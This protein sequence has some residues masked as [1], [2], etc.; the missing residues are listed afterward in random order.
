MSNFPS[1]GR[2]TRKNKVVEAGSKTLVGIA[3]H[4]RSIDSAPKGYSVQRPAAVANGFLLFFFGMSAILLSS[5]L[6]IK[7]YVLP[8]M[9][10]DLIFFNAGP[11]FAVLPV[12]LFFLSYFLT[13]ALFAHAKVSMK[14]W[15]AISFCGKSILLWMII[16]GIVFLIWAEQRIIVPIFVQQLIAGIGA[17][18][19]FPHTIMANAHLP[20]QSNSP[21]TKR[22]PVMGYLLLGTAF[23]F[24]FVIALWLAWKLDETIV[25][26]RAIALLGGLGPGVFLVQQAFA[27]FMATI[28]YSM[29]VRSGR[30]EFAP[31]IAILVPAHNEAHGIADCIAS[32]D[33]AAETYDGHVKL[34]IVDNCSRDDTANV[35]KSALTQASHI[36][37]EVFYCGTPGKAVALNYGLDHISE[38]F[39]VRIDA[40]TAIGDD[41]LHIA[42]NHF[43][44]PN[45]GAV[46]GLPLPAERTGVLNRIRLIEILLR[47]GFY[48]IALSGFGGVLGVPGMFAVY[49][50]DAVTEAGGTTEGMNGEDTDLVLRITN[51]GYEAIV[52]PRAKYYSEVPDTYTHLR[53]QRLRWFRSL[54]HIAAHNRSSLFN[55]R[56]ITGSVVLPFMLVNAARRAMLAPLL[57]Y[58]LLV[59]LLFGALYTNLDIGPILA[60]M[61][62]MP[63]CMS[64][65]VLLLWR[66][67]TALP[68]IPLYLVFR[69]LRGYFTLAS[70][71]TLTFHGPQPESKPVSQPQQQQA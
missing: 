28:G 14:L 58:A 39:V 22:F 18:A 59:Y 8:N 70:V 55:P 24:G 31:D 9:F 64:I 11:H 52:D 1:A 56:L 34:Y 57:L 69:I 47:H 68:T 21:I 5:H 67:V 44:R 36:T 29:T 13:F 46:G 51:L 6:M 23:I 66:R 50:R 35:A 48:Q 15:L 61:F 62:G 20:R 37:G 43:A 25:F 38:E 40:D 71:L 63:L 49:R 42:M 26:L 3:E 65:A 41:C 16:D 4:F 12:R 45:V 19:V 54:Y 2:K 7:A 27:F 32:V 33:H 10:L 17:L 60:V 30:Q 53:E